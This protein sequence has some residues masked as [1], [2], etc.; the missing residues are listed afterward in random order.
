[1]WLLD[2]SHIRI[3]VIRKSVKNLVSISASDRVH[4]LCLL[5][6]FSL[7][8][9]LFCKKELYGNIAEKLIDVI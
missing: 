3:A 6:F 5:A 4:N 2:K 8:Y 9:S 7:K 1:M